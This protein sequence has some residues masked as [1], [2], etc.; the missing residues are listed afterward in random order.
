[1]TDSTFTPLS[2]PESVQFTRESLLEPYN[3]ALSYKFD[4]IRFSIQNGN[5]YSRTG[6][7]IPNDHIRNTLLSWDLPNGVDGELVSGLNFQ[8]T[9]SAV[10]SF[11]GTPTFSANIFDIV[12]IENDKPFKERYNGL[13]EIFS[14]KFGLKEVGSSSAE[15]TNI[16]NLWLAKHHFVNEYS[17]IE[18]WINIF[19]GAEGV[20]LR[21]YY[22]KYYE[23]MWKIKHKKNSE[24]K[25]LD[26]IQLKRKTG[27]LADQVGSLL[28]EDI[29]SKKQFNIGTGFTKQNRIDLWNMGDKLIGKFVMYQYDYVS[30][31]GIPRFPRFISIR[32]EKD[33]ID[34]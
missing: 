24:A 3:L 17:H 15:H 1:M 9:T 21:P 20:V 26:I 31:Y 14:N 23:K 13:R 33:I 11:D 27:E 30:T 25:V 19:E 4:G 10:M 18:Y 7:I 34:K 32:D 8:D 16:E 5:V 28:V 6:K 2:R 29:F 12:P 22:G